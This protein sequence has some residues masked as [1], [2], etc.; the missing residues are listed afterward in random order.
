MKQM[1]ALLL[2]LFV[3]FGLAHRLTWTAQSP[4]IPEFEWV[5]IDQGNGTSAALASTISGD[6]IFVGGSSS[7]IVTMVNAQTGEELTVPRDLGDGSQELYNQELFI[8]KTSLDGRP[9]AMW[10]YLGTSF[11]I[12]TDLAISE[13]GNFLAMMASIVGNVTLG[14]FHV[15]GSGDTTL[16]KYDTV[17]AKLSASTGEVFWV[18]HYPS[19][20]SFFNGRGSLAFDA[21]GNVLVAGMN[22][23]EIGQTPCAACLAAADGSTLWDVNFAGTGIGPPV[24]LV[25]VDY[26]DGKLYMPGTMLGTVTR[27]G[28]SISSSSTDY[29]DALLL[30][31][32]AS[33]GTLL[34]AATVSG[35]TAARGSTVA[36]RDDAIYMSCVGGCS[37][38]RTTVSRNFAIFEGSSTGGV[39]KIRIDGVPL[40]AVDLGIDWAAG[41]VATEESV[42]IK[43]AVGTPQKFGETTF[44]PWGVSDY[45]ILKIFADT[46]AGD[47][48]LQAGG[49]GF[50]RTYENLEVDANGDLYAVGSTRSKPIYFDPLV[51]DGHS[52]TDGEDIFVAKLKASQEKLPFCKTSENTVADGYCFVNNVCYADGTPARGVSAEACMSCSAED[53][54]A[55]FTT[56]AGYCFIDGVCHADGASGTTCQ[57]C[58]V[59]ISTDSWTLRSDRYTL[60][61]DGSCVALATW[62]TQSPTI[63]EF[64]WVVVD[65]GMTY[66]LGLGAASTSDSIFVAG[67]T[68]NSITLFNAQ[69][70]ESLTSTDEGGDFD[71]YIAKVSFDGTPQKVWMYPGGKRGTRT[72]VELP[73]H[74]ASS[75]DEMYLAMVGYFEVNMTFGNETFTTS[76]TGRDG[77]VAKISALNGE[78]IW[79]RSFPASGDSLT[80]G[81]VF[82]ADGNVGVCGRKCE[83]TEAGSSS[84]TAYVAL[85]AAEDGDFVWELNFESGMDYAHDIE[86]ADGKFYVV[87]RLIGTVTVDDVVL[88]SASAERH[89]AMLLVL[90]ADGTGSWGATIVG[91]GT[92]AI[93]EPIPKSTLVKVVGESIYLS[94]VYD[95]LEVSTTASDVTVAVPSAAKTSIAKISTTGVPVWIADMLVDVWAVY[96][97]DE[98]ASLGMTA[99]TDAVYINYGAYGYQ[100]YGALTEFEDTRA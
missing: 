19:V 25:G 80:V 62:T 61:A 24:A 26:E 100:L 23:C 8:A 58:N 1:R 43:Y 63:P 37:E 34:W 5:V 31:L 30:V 72:F 27:D 38:V 94:C 35:E 95:C 60:A 36:V 3:P 88:S 53:S 79:A 81:T 11:E 46:G 32:D 13:D 59:S 75:Q 49:Q 44:T 12:V 57:Y 99:T 98:W 91:S 83:V 21:D 97:P 68:T 45:F 48:V 64:E 52:L 84:C 20:G 71:M 76:G 14:D 2:S 7:G 74:L 10:T 69:T 15:V 96:I 17:V 86:Y 82:D 90:N 6:A 40:W 85:L 70:M 89:D 41:I 65:Y 29:T 33:D 16:S 4:T 77:Y 42:Y 51:V 18:R 66:N 67:V 92:R 22:P 73:L 55:S 87:G 9:E 78:V 28:V 50:E 47:W 39:A 93:D 56:A 54:K